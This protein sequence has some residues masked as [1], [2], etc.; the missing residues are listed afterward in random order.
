M[1]DPRVRALGLATL[2]AWLLTA[3]IGAF[4]LRTWIAGGGLRRQRATGV[5]VPPLA[6]WAGFL[7]TSSVVLAWLDV[8]IVCGAITLGICMVTL[9]TPYPVMT[10]SP[11]QSPPEQDPSEQRPPE[12]GRWDRGPLG[13]RPD[14]PFTVTDEMIAALLT[15]PFPAR[16]RRGVNLAPLIPVCHGFAAI[17][18]FLLVTLTAASVM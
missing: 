18:T 12:Q 5:G 7:A 13:Q 15:E 9:W 1:T 3:G 2:A 4:M 11:E 10:P 14:D 6:V 8:V 16:K 17:A